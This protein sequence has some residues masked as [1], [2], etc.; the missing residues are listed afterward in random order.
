[1]LPDPITKLIRDEQQRQQNRFIEVADLDAYL[2]KL[3]D[4]AEFLSDLLGDR[5][6]GVVAFYCNDEST[7]RAYI[8]LVLVDPHDRGLGIGRT[9]V[10]G[11]LRIARE[12]GFTSCALEVAK[13]STAAHALYQSLGFTI[14]EARGGKDLMEIAL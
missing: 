8:T 7:R 11:V 12:R 13:T 5:C 6:R 2:A 10:A 9:L 4:N 3:N 1:M 14:V